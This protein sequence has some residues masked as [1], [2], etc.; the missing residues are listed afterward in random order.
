MFF[1][2]TIKNIQRTREIIAVLFK[3]GF[4]EVVANTPLQNFVPQNRQ[5]TWLRNERYVLDYT[6]WERVRMVFEELGPTFIKG[7]QVLSNRP[8]LLPEPLITEF[9]KLQSNVPPFPFEEAKA[10]IEKELGKKLEEVFAFFNPVPIGSA[11]IGQVHRARLLD[12]TEVV[13]KVQRPQVRQIV[14]TDLAIL[15]EVIR[16][17]EKFFENNGIIN[18]MDLVLAFEKSMQKE[19]DYLTEARNITQFRTFYQDRKDF[20]VPKAF[21]ELSTAKVLLLEFVKGCKITDVEQLTKWGVDIPEIAKT[22]LNIYMTQIFEFGFF[23]ADPHPGNILIRPDG[24]ICLID[25]GMV[26]KLMPKDKFAF[27]GVFTA[28]ALKDAK[29]MVNALRRLAIDDDIQDVKTLE[30]DLNELIEDYTMLDVSESSMAEMAQRLQAIIYEHKIRVPGSI[31]II[32]RALAILE[33]I[34]KT[35]YPEMNVYDFVKPYGQ[36][37]LFEQ[38]RPENVG[39]ELLDVLNDTVRFLNSFPSEIKDILKKIRQGRISSEIRIAEYDRFIAVWHYTANRL[40]MTLLIMALVIGAAIIT[41][42]DIIAHPTARG[43]PWT[44]G[45]GYLIAALLALRLM[46]VS[47]RNGKY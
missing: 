30:N 34:G 42:A 6:R 28:M 5:L 13:V 3:Y 47:F 8:D 29:S 17:S 33:G 32:L 4:E 16:R 18:P 12:D 23:H 36:K 45:T 27:T 44:A 26:G 25:F 9:Q 43:I 14:E 20:Y 40:A 15:K 2:Q 22:G 10:I 41:A 21:K 37:M 35:I 11:S 39:R 24:V 38:F 31:F 7:A 19:L 46:L 1:T